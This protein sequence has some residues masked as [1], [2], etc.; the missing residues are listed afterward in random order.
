M[1]IYSY[2]KK[3]LLYITTC[4]ALFALVFAGCARKESPDNRTLVKLSN[5]VITLKEF[6]A[7]IAKLPPYYRDVVE[8]NKKR[9]LD[10]I[11]METL[12][13]E[14]A[15][16][17]GADRD[18]EVKEVIADAKKKIVM[19]KYV[20][21]EVEDNVKVTDAET[22]QYYEYNKDKFKTPEL[23]RASHILVATEKDAQDILDA[24]SKGASFEE[25]AKTRS[26]DATAS[27]GGDIGYFK[28]GQLVPDFEN[29][30]LKLN[31]GQTSGIVHTRFGYHIIKLTDK[32]ESVAESYDKAKRAIEED[33]KKRKRAELFDKLVT[34]LKEKYGVDIKEDVFNSLEPVTPKKEPPNKI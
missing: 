16:R 2:M 20:K 24:L 8:K 15:V 33:L 23:R 26:M 1:V 12:L 29:V 25:L 9:Y 34:K 4:M 13:Y 3:K 14:E 27:R 6:K 7:R 10:E 32:K 5:R 31:I 22:K 11:I 28:Q 30:C 19:A 18:K 17:S 21:S